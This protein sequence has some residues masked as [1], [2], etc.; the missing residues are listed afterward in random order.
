MQTCEVFKIERGMPECSANVSYYTD[1]L[2]IWK[3]NIPFRENLF[4]LGEFR[5][6][7]SPLQRH[8]LSFIISQPESFSFFLSEVLITALPYSRRT[9]WERNTC[10]QIALRR[11]LA[12]CTAVSS[13]DRGLSAPGSGGSKPQTPHRCVLL[14]TFYSVLVSISLQPHPT[15]V[16]SL[17]PFVCVFLKVYN[18]LSS[19]CNHQPN[20]ISENNKKSLLFFFTSNLSLTRADL[21]RLWSPQ[22]ST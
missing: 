18:H 11:S 20:K 1:I 9:H 22:G 16:P 8:P 3:Q 19:D 15:S 5:L 10:Q 12:R 21:G 2:S 4:L 14:L 13:L 17:F 7:S 6:A